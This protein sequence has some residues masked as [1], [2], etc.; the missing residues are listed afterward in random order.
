MGMVL[1][2]AWLLLQLMVFSGCQSMPGEGYGQGGASDFE[3]MHTVTY[4]SRAAM[5]TKTH[6]Q[7][8]QAVRIGGMS[9]VTYL[10]PAE[11]G[12][13]R[14]AFAVVCDNSDLVVCFEARFDPTGRIRELKVQ[15]AIRLEEKRDFEGIA[16]LPSSPGDADSLKVYLSEENTP[17]V[18]LVDMRQGRLMD[19]LP[20]PQIFAERHKNARGRAV[21]PMRRNRGFEALA[22]NHVGSELWTANEEAL[23]PDGPKSSARQGSTVRLVRYA[24]FAD[25]AVA[26]AQYAYLCDP[27][28]AG[29]GKYSA[30]G[31]VELVVTPSGRL[32]AM[33]RSS[34]MSW[35]TPFRNRIYELDLRQATDVTSFSRGL[36]GQEYTPVAKQLLWQSPPSPGNLEGLC[37]GPQLPDGRY[38]MLGVVDNGDPISENLVVSFVLDTR[39][40]EKATIARN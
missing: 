39:V 12:V 13:D 20:T 6:D 11:H 15:R 28:H 29:E 27:L 37:M 23:T 25:P 40:D 34:G 26:T 38:V 36:D 35:L 7:F 21:R 32:L 9:G 17:G 33:E 10:G 1:G 16:L 8:D 24:L 30:S 5:P 3:P 18:V 22:A 19:L 2:Q 14:H 4:R 31:L